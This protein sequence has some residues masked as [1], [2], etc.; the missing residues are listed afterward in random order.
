MQMIKPSVRKRIESM[1]E[2]VDQMNKIQI[3][4]IK[5]DALIDKMFEE[6]KEMLNKI[7]FFKKMKKAV[8]K[9]NGK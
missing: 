3:D 4:K 6:R 9:E 1:C 5:D 2:D 8:D 7:A